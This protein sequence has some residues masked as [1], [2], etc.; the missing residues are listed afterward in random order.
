MK[1]PD[2]APDWGRLLDDLMAK[3][4][5]Q[6]GIA[7]AM[8]LTTITESMLRTWRNGVQPMYFRGQALVMLWCTTMG[9]ELQDVPTTQVRPGRWMGRRT[10]DTS[11]KAANLPQWPPSPQPT[12]KPGKKQRVAA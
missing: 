3:G 5:S 10:V 1:A 4:M 12:V 7:D 2:K 11:P 9:K 6:R 8:Q